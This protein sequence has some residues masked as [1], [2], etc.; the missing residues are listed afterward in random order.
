MVHLHSLELQL[1]LLTIQSVSP[2]RA[3]KTDKTVTKSLG[4]ELCSKSYTFWQVVHRN[5]NQPGPFQA[6]GKTIKINNLGSNPASHQGTEAKSASH[7]KRSE[8][9]KVKGKL[10]SI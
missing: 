7:M 1:R 6:T 4:V 2:T 5:A 8:R 9:Q 3:A 10:M